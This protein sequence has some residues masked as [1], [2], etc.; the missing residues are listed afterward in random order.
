MDLSGWGKWP[1]LPC[2]LLTCRG[3]QDIAAAI[4][5]AT[6]LIARGNGRSYGDAALNPAATLSMLRHDRL[7][8]FDP[9]TGLLT[10]DAGVLLA[11]ILEVFVP[12]GWF[13]TVTPGTRLVTVGGMIAADVH[14]KNHHA[15]GTFGETVD[16]LRL[17]AG[18]GAVH[19]CSRSENADLFAA[20]CGGMGL[21]GVIVDATFRLIPIETGWIRQETVKAKNLD[22]VL[23]AFETAGGWPYTVAWIDCLARGRN[24]GRSLLYRGDHVPLEHL[25]A[26][27]R[28]APLA[29]PRRPA[30][31]VPLN[32]PAPLLAPWAVR[33]FNA[34]YH[35]AGKPGTRLVDWESFFYPLD[36]LRDWNRLYGRRGFAQYQCVLP[37]AA[38]EQGLRALLDCISAAGQGSFL[39]VLKLLGKQNRNLLSFPLEGYTLALDF[40]IGAPTLALFPRLDEIVGRHGGRLYLAKDAR[41]PAGMLRSGYDRL[42]RFLRIRDHIGATGRFSSA[43]SRRLGLS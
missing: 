38:G 14:G 39:A 20:T 27:L 43:L 7:H 32:C 17:M 15:A 23:A 37:K 31:T 36:G 34:A 42:D 8:D 5:G 3:R 18:D 19:H 12:R 28:A 13:P 29:P 33:A 30:L 10:C 6:A 1:R 24:M 9:A 41:M 22:A 26:P 35:A 21:T 25:P 11:D 2:R 16:S 4:T 40:P